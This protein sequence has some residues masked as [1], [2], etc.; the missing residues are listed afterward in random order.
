MVSVAPTLVYDC[1]ISEATTPQL[2]AS[3][4]TATLHL[5]SEGGGDDL[6]GMADTVAN[7]LPHA[8][9]RS[10]PGEWHGV[11]DDVLA[12]TLTDFFRR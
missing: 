11:P 4:M 7:L 8:A 5:N 12:A 3:V 2:L 9:R 6:T 10:L 1:R